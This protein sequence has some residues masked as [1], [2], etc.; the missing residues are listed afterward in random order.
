MKMSVN[1]LVDEEDHFFAGG[2]ARRKF[3]SGA[4]RGVEL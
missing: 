3:I 1:G 2:I 4:T